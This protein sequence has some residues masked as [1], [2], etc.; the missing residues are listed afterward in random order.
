MQA[1]AGQLSWLVPEIS[2]CFIWWLCPLPL[3]LGHAVYSSPRWPDHSVFAVAWCFSAVL[4][5]PLMKPPWFLPSPLL[6]GS[7][8]LASPGLRAFSGPGG[9]SSGPCLGLLVWGELIRLA[10]GIRLILCGNWPSGLLLGTGPVCTAAVV[11]S[12]CRPHKYLPP[13]SVQRV[14][15]STHGVQ[16]HCDYIRCSVWTGGVGW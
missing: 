14:C 5:V 1:G 8:L 11:G 13:S 4:L 16:D 6:S 10:W 2:Y 15:C 12:A 7:L 9:R 3:L